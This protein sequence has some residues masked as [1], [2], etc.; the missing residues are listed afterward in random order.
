MDPDPTLQLPEDV[1]KALE[2][3]LI[4]VYAKS[5]LL[6]GF[7]IQRQRSWSKFVDAP[8]KLGDVDKYVK[9]LVESGSQLAQAADNCEKHCSLLNRSAIKELSDLAKES[10]QAILDQRQVPEMSSG[11]Q[12]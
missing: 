2:K 4:Q 11:E 1:L 6:L 10:H 9:G 8:F 5:L 3:S 12:R 7:A